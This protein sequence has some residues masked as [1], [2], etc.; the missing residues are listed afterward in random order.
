MSPDNMNNRSSY[1]SSKGFVEPVE[2]VNKCY[3]LQG[4]GSFLSSNMNI[5]SKRQHNVILDRYM[6]IPKD[7]KQQSLVPLNHEQKKILEK[8]SDLQDI[9]KMKGL[10]HL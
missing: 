4:R 2:G 10:Q 8:S 7:R 5:K 6:P 1:M 9:F 3:N